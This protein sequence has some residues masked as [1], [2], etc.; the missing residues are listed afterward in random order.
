MLM[1]VSFTSHYG[2]FSVPEGFRY[3]Q[4]L[5]GLTLNSLHI[6]KLKPDGPDPSYHETK[7]RCLRTHCI[8]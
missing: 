7:A 6:T 3:V 8:E 2:V 1:Y 4:E 5:L